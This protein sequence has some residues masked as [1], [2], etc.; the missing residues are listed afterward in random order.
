ML[1]DQLPLERI[2]WFSP[3]FRNSN[4]FSSPDSFSPSARVNILVFKNQAHSS[5]A[6]VWLLYENMSRVIQ[7][8]DSVAAGILSH[9]GALLLVEVGL[10][11]RGTHKCQMNP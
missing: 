2:I 6:D 8:L 11:F 5:S 1:I 10:H 4:P 7:S 3:P 9:A